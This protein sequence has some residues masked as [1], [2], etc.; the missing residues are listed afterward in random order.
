MDSEQ[1]KQ[2]DKLLHAALRARRRKSAT[3]FCEKRV[4]ATNGWSAKRAPC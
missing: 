1:W 3:P 2:L 4:P